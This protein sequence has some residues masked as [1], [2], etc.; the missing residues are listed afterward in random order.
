MRRLASTAILLALMTTVASAQTVQPRNDQNRVEA[1][2]PAQILTS[3]PTEGVTVTHWYKQNVYDPNDSK[4]GEI[5]DVLVDKSGKAT[6]L[7]VGV[8]GFL[9]A[10]EKDVAVPFDAVRAAKKG[11][12]D[13][14]LVMNSSKDALKNA[15]GFKYDRNEMTWIPE[16]RARTT[17]GSGTNNSAP[18]PRPNAR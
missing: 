17:T 2:P 18:A 6:A 7:I 5:M 8:G 9:G 14:Y 13:W 10:G 3:I 16:D 1:G 12:N 4:I 11:N 15:K